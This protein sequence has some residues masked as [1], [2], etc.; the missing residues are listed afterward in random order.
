MEIILEQ[1]TS[2]NLCHTYEIRREDIP[3]EFVDTA[4]TIAQTNEYGLENG[5]IG[6]TFLASLDGR[7]IGLIMIGEALPWNSDP[8][9]MKSEPFYRLMGFVIDREY[10]SR[11]F[12]GEIL[13]KAIEQVYTDYGRR[14]VMLGCHRNNTAAARFYKRHGFVSRSI[15][16]GD[17]EY[18]LF[19]PDNGTD[20]P[21]KQG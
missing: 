6:H 15:Y 11:G 2:E 16:E 4:E 7:Y 10:R 19:Y 5:L 12:G 1:L 21:Q 13:R 3:E 17:D 18:F 8:P 14:P 9:E 20:K